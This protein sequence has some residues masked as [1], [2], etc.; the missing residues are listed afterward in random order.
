MVLPSKGVLALDH[1][2]QEL[3]GEFAGLPA[4]IQAVCHD[5]QYDPPDEQE[6]HQTHIV[7]HLILEREIVADGL[8][9]RFCEP[10]GSSKKLR[11]ATAW[12]CC[13]SLAE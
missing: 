12:L 11:N 1:V 5:P 9:I 6:N 3:I 13:S 8:M 10:G 4:I 7:H 2:L